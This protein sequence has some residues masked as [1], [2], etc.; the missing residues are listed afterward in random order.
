MLHQLLIN[1]TVIK[2]D[3][4]QEKGL[5]QTA[6]NDANIQQARLTSNNKLKHTATKFYDE[7]YERSERSGLLLTVQDVNQM[8]ND[9]VRDKKIYKSHIPFLQRN[10]IG[11]Y[12]YCGSLANSAVTA[13]N[14]YFVEIHYDKVSEGIPHKSSNA[15]NPEFLYQV[16]KGL[17][18][19]NSPKDIYML[20]SK[21]IDI[22][23]NHKVWS[24]FVDMFVQLYGDT[25]TL[26][27]LINTEFDKQRRY[28]R[29]KSMVFSI[30]N[31][32]FDFM[33]GD[34]IG[35]LLAGYWAFA[36]GLLFTLLGSVF[37]ETRV[38]TKL[39]CKSTDAIIDGLIHSK[40]PMY[41]FTTRIRKQLEYEIQRTH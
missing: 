15:Y 16:L 22:I 2:R 17:K 37:G 39:K 4:E 5:F 6:Y 8:I 10:L 23:R 1:T 13:Y 21:D 28:D 24:E 34:I 30:T 11:S 31:G 38:H 7:F 29:V 20:T 25:G 41:V 36:V 33:L 32:I 26:Q 27:T 40:E 9:L 35:L 12:Y 14:P 19:I 3:N 18:I